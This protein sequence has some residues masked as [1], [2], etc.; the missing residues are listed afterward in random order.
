MKVWNITIHFSVW[1]FFALSVLWSLFKHFLVLW[2]YI[3]SVLWIRSSESAWLYFREC[4]L[5][6]NKK[7]RNSLD[8]KECK[9]QECRIKCK[10]KIAIFD[11]YNDML[12]VIALKNGR[13]KIHQDWISAIDSFQFA[14]VVL[15]PLRCESRNTT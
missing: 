10:F 11:F 12:L 14:I 1:C 7:I 15:G 13:G 2:Y 5:I 4:L 8:L 3:F 9:N 6:G